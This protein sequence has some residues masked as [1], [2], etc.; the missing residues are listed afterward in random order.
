[1]NFWQASEWRV[2]AAC[3]LTGVHEMDGSSEVDGR[4]TAQGFLQDIR[5]SSCCSDLVGWG[6]KNKSVAHSCSTW[7]WARDLELGSNPS[8]ST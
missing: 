2:L 3:R 6:P 5:V 1:M 4:E 8:L 7:A